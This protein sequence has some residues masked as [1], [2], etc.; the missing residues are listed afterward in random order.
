MSGSAF[1][2]F[3]FLL[4][5]RHRAKHAAV[6]VMAVILVVLFN[7]VMFLSGAVQKDLLQTLDDQADLTIQR[8]RAG[9]VVDM[10]EIWADSF[11][12]IPGVSVVVPRVYGRYFHEPNGAYFTVVGVDL[13]D[14]QATGNLQALV[15]SLDVRSFLG[16]KHMIVGEGVRSFLD[17]HHYTDHYDFKTPHGVREEVFVHS[18]LPSD[19]N[20]VGHDLAIMEINLARTVLGLA[21]DQATDVVLQVPNEL[22]RDTVMGKAIGAHYDIRVIRKTEIATAYRGLFNYKGGVFLL[23]YLIALVTYGLILY[24]R[25]AMITGTD[26]RDV[27][28]MRAVGWSIRDVITLKVTESLIVALTAFLVG[29][30]C[31]YLYV[32]ILGAPGLSAVFFGFHNL[33]VDVTLGRTLD[34]GRLALAFLV[35]VV[36]F[37]AA[38]LVPVW[39]IAITEPVEAMK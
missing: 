4:L 6:F 39:R 20:L 26:K 32:F 5:Y 18:V 14:Q 7:S 34:P 33:P 29:T 27:G 28:I 16:Q 15:D 11:A 36:P 8:I 2:N 13:F 23:L 24:Q 17:T 37:V 38:V 10:P 19:C 12:E 21:R 22:E 1:I 35:F 30:V 9:K 3:L 31:A 25:Y